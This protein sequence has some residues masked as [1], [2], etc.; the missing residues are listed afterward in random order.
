MKKLIA[1]LSI[2]TLLIA[3]STFAKDSKS[4]SNQKV[5]DTF[6][7]EF[8][9][10]SDVTWYTSDSKDS[11]VARFTIKETKVTAHFDKHGN[12]LATSRYISDS[13]LP[14]PVITRLMNRY[15]NENI[16]NIVEYTVSGQVS[17]VITLENTTQ[18]KVVKA[19][20]GGALSI[21]QKLRKA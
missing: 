8:V 15:P 17:Y 12:L 4:I 1:I 16:R 14:L 11:Y 3:N 6:N 10:A 19:H 21:M 7:E 18:W 2:A 20:P 13:D 5:M 9:G